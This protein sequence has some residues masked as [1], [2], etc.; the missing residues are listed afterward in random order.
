MAFKILCHAPSR[1]S[2]F[3]FL[4]RYQHSGVYAGSCIARISSTN[5]RAE[6]QPPEISVSLKRCSGPPFLRFNA[7]DGSTISIIVAAYFNPTSSPGPRTRPPKSQSPPRQPC[8]SSSSPSQTSQ[9][10][11]IMESC[12]RA[13]PLYIMLPQRLTQCFPPPPC[14]S[15]VEQAGSTIRRST[16]PRL[17]DV[18]ACFHI[19]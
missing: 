6:E 10:F 12:W 4:I 13:P 7:E 9:N 1:I 19:D 3:V 16:Y 2:C 18:L 15:Q 14:L 17:P 5:R 8:P 11:S